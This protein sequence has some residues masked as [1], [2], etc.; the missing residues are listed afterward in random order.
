M[1]NLG[2]ILINYQENSLDWFK[3]SGF[4]DFYIYW[5]KIW[6]IF[7]TIPKLDNPY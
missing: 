3:L 5:M 2:V 1:Q 4:P 7:E 6:K